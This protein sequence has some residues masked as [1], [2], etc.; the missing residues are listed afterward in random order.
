MQ[1][2]PKHRLVISPYQG[3][4]SFSLPLLGLAYQLIVFDPLLGAGFQLRL[5]QLSAIPRAG[6]GSYLC[7]RWQ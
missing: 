1:S 7:H 2:Q 6:L 3:I 4:E 5:R